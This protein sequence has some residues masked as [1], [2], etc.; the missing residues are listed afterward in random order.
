MGADHACLSPNA[1]TKRLPRASVLLMAIPWLLVPG[2]AG[3]GI[4]RGVVGAVGSE[5]VLQRGLLLLRGLR[6]RRWTLPL[7]VHHAFF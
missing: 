4:A 5:T 2:W 1:F 6:Q 7:V 3:R